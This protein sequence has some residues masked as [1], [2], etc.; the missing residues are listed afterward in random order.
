MWLLG[1]Q[2]WR[3]PS[4][5]TCFVRDLVLS[6]IDKINSLNSFIASRDLCGLPITFANSLA[7][8]FDTLLLF[9]KDVFWK[10]SLVMPNRV[11]R[12][13][14]FYP[15]LT[16]MADSYNLTQAFTWGLHTLV[17]L[18][19]MHMVVLLFC[20]QRHELCEKGSTSFVDHLCYLSLVFFMLS[21]L[22]IAAWERPDLLAQVC[23]V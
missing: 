20:K 7:K 13:G 19:L 8:P 4:K 18:E 9:L 22:F 16:I 14:F 1:Y 11:P 23:D 5:F 17:V 21:R 12:G 10:I 2:S 15:T 3:S 6:G